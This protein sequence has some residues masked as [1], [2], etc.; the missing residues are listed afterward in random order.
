M[1]TPV[2]DGLQSPWST[3][4]VFALAGGIA[5]SGFAVAAIFISP[6]SKIP[7]EEIKSLQEA[8]RIL[9]SVKTK[10]EHAKVNYSF[11]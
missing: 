4:F 11:I 5:F 6:N 8:S 10:I 2:L 1:E 7:D 3:V 9:G